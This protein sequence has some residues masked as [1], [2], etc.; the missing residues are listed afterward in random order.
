MLQENQVERQIPFPEG[1]LEEMMQRGEQELAMLRR[2][3]RARLQNNYHRKDT[4]HDD[5][6]MNRKPQAI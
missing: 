5:H 6:G 1:F 3:R 4:S 2:C